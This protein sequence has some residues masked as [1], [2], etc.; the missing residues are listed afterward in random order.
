MFVKEVKNNVYSENDNF[1]DF[2][3]NIILIS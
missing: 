2:L 3:Q 1:I